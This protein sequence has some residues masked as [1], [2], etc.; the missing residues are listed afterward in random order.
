[1]FILMAQ[2]NENFDWRVKNLSFNIRVA[3]A[4]GRIRGNIML[5]ML[6][7]WRERGGKE[8]GR[9]GKKKER[10]E[11]ESKGNTF[12][13]KCFLNLIFCLGKGENFF[14]FASFLKTQILEITM[15]VDPCYGLNIQ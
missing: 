12:I 13:S 8:R 15:I 7:K 5:V 11:R 9:E 4:V 1:M 3:W 6:R 2:G 10:V 14:F